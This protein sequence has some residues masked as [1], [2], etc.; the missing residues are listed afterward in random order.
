MAFQIIL[1]GVINCPEWVVSVH[2]LNI[3][4]VMQDINFMLIFSWL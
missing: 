4:K 1:S 3:S 2:E